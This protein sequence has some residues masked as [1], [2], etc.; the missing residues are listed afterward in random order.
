MKFRKILK[1]LL[2]AVVSLN[3]CTEEI[4]ENELNV[5]IG[6]FNSGEYDK[7]LVENT[8]LLE[9]QAL[10][11]YLCMMKGRILFNMGDEDEGIVMTEIALKLDPNYREARVYNLSMKTLSSKYSKKDVLLMIEDALKKIPN[12]STL[13]GMEASIYS[14]IGDSNQAIT[15]YEK[16]L[17]IYPNYYDS[18]LD[19]VKTLHKAGMK[20]SAYEE[21]SKILISFPANVRT[22]AERGM[23]YLTDRKY[24]KALSDFNKVISSPGKESSMMVEYTAFPYN[25]RGFAYFKLGNTD[26][27]L[28]DISHSLE[29]LPTN[30]Y[31]YKNKALVQISLGQKSEACTNLKKARQLGYTEKYGLEVEKIIEENCER[32]VN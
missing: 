18:K 16:L 25:N 9:K 15:K 29:L 30:S 13:L 8:E 11:P 17:S 14:E 21:F 12:D 20:E 23:C 2:L 3:S 22:Y 26:K 19:Y 7:A 5:M 27:A 1:L 4:T 31:A 10:S 28:E 6:Y 32:E 24:E